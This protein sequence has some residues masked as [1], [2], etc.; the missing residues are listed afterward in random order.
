MLIRKID[1]FSLTFTVITVL[2]RSRSDR[3][4]GYTFIFT[5]THSSGQAQRLQGVV[6][7]TFIFTVT[8]SK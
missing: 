6:G 7:Y 5:V 2:V 8:H 4:V 1:Y 3:Y